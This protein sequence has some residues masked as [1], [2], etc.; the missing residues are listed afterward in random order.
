MLF[1]QADFKSQKEA[2]YAITN[3]LSE[4]SIEQ[5]GILIQKGVLAPFTAL[6]ESKDVKTVLV[7]LEGLTTLLKVCHHILINVK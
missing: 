7:I 6:L 5:V 4:C 1:C 2:A 3:Y